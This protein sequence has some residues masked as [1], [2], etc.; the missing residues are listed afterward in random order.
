MDSIKFQAP[1]PKDEDLEVEHSLPAKY[2]VCQDCKGCGSVLSEAIRN[3]GYSQEEMNEDP[4]FAEEYRKGGD[5]IY[6]VSC[7]TCNGLRVVLVPDE[8]RANPKILKLYYTLKNEE[9]RQRR[10]DHRTYLMECGLY[11]EC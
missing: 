10:E 1:D 7:P 5:G 11:G 8:S 2:G 6:G 4:D 3:H 9:A